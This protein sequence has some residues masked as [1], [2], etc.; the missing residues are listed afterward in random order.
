M[1]GSKQVDVMA[2]LELAIGKNDHDTILMLWLQVNTQLRQA[3]AMQKMLS[4]KTKK[5]G[6]D[7]ELLSTV[8]KLRESFKD[9]EDSSKSLLDERTVVIED[10]E[11]ERLLMDAKIVELEEY[12]KK[13]HEEFVELSTTSYD[14]LK[15]RKCKAYKDQIEQKTKLLN[16]MKELQ[17]RESSFREEMKAY[18]EVNLEQWEA[19]TG[20]ENERLEMYDEEL[21]AQILAQQNRSEFLA[22]QLQDFMET[23]QKAD[24]SRQATRKEIDGKQEEIKSACDEIDVLKANLIEQRQSV[25]TVKR[26]IVVVSNKTSKLDEELKKLETLSSRYDNIMVIL[27]SS[28][29]GKSDSNSSKEEEQQHNEEAVAEHEDRHEDEDQH[30]DG[31]EDER[32]Q[33][34]ELETGNVE[35][36]KRRESSEEEI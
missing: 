18:E 24:L 9:I 4:A 33:E 36:E 28:V 21:L 13:C 27:E 19:W 31:A 17:Q 1:S 20:C 34:K 6:G 7:D 8:I 22:H 3:E 30:A 15:E 2:E 29:N 5:S 26:K 23:F 11:K 35:V 32:K 25:D 10:Y 16:R 12:R 14:E